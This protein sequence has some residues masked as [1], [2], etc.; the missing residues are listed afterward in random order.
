MMTT[1]PDPNNPPPE[2][3]QAGTM[4]ETTLQ[5]MVKLGIPPQAIASA[6]L[7]G[8]LHFLSASLPEEQVIRVLTNAINGVKAGQLRKA[9]PR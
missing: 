4:L 7:G 3:Q 6:L 8:T 2:L 1:H 5:E 9:P